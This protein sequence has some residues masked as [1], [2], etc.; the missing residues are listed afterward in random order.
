M[1]EDE[2]KTKW[3]PFARTSDDDGSTFNR[4]WDG[5]VSEA[6]ACLGSGCM[7]WRW[8][9]KPMRQ[10]SWTPVEGWEHSPA[11]PGDPEDRDYW[12]QPQEDAVRQRP[13]YC[14]LAGAP[15]AS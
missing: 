6:A 15:H 3:C 9:Q 4:R 14:G 2:A 12:L 10:A 7:A 1:T 13:G 5:K 11:D 8:L